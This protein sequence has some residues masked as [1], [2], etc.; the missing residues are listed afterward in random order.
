[1]LHSCHRML[2]VSASACALLQVPLL[3]LLLLLELQLPVVR[4]SPP[5]LKVPHTAIVGIKPSLFAVCSVSVLG[6]YPIALLRSSC[7][8]CFQVCCCICLLLLLLRRYHEKLHTV[9]ST[10]L[11]YVGSNCCKAQGLDESVEDRL[12]L[13]IYYMTHN[14]YRYYIHMY[15]YIFTYVC[16]YIFTYMSIYTR[17]F[18]PPNSHHQNHIFCRGSLFHCSLTAWHP[19]RRS[20]PIH[21]PRENFNE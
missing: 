10:H 8:G 9:V 12:N 15:I 3:T 5:L 17:G 1:M 20:T 7:P 19:G 11:L 4:M 2:V 6:C 13:N 14:I 21:F 18:P 16:I